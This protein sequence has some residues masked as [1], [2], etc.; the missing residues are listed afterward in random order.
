MFIN[1]FILMIFQREIQIT[2]W[3]SL[4]WNSTGKYVALFVKERKKKESLWSWKSV[5]D[6][7]PPLSHIEWTPL[8]LC[9]DHERNNILLTF[10]FILEKNLYLDMSLFKPLFLLFSP[11][12]SLRNFY[13]SLTQVVH[14]HMCVRG[15]HQFNPSAQHT[16]ASLHTHI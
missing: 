13:T 9:I 8:S 5:I 11:F 12:D 14:T 3:A 1:Q 2:W 6:I 16:H 10:S 4:T 7:W 15:V